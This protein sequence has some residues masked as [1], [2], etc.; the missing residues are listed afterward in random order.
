MVAETSY[1]EAR[2]KIRTGDLIALRSR[3][4]LFAW[5]TR[6]VT[7]SPYTHTAVALWANERL[8]VAEAKASG[9]MLVPLSQYAGTDFDVFPCPVDCA[10]AEAQAWS[11]LG[12][13]RG[14]DIIDLLAIA[15]NRL[16]GVPLPKRDDEE[17]ICSAASASIYRLAGWQP[18]FL[19]SIPAPV[20]VVDAL[21]KPPVLTLRKD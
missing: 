14:Y 20:D 1:F 6:L 13:H 8:L 16:L 17:L 11:Y 4:G 21:G 19:P 12:L 7:Q 3:R 2:D 18:A 15:A 9:N 10:K 5:V